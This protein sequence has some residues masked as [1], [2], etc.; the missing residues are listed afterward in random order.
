MFRVRLNVAEMCENE[1]CGHFSAAAP[2]L[3]RDALINLDP[4]P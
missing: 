2:W 4:C 1:R 3:R